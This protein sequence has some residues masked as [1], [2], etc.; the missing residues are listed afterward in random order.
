MCWILSHEA[1]LLRRLFHRRIVEAFVEAFDGRF[2]ASGCCFRRFS[3]LQSDESATDDEDDG[4]YDDKNDENHVAVD[5][6]AVVGVSDDVNVIDDLNGKV[7]S[8]L[9]SEFGFYLKCGVK[10]K[11]N[12]WFSRQFI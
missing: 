7:G 4:K 9:L 10:I 8:N 3:P 1:P 12:W 2:V 5:F 6:V 11:C